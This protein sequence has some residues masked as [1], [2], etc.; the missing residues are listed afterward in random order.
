MKKLLGYFMQIF[1][2]MIQMIWN[3]WFWA[4]ASFLMLISLKKSSLQNFKDLMFLLEV[5]SLRVLECHLK[6]LLII[7]PKNLIFEYRVLADM[8]ATILLS[9]SVP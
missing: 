8:I 2:K 5:R 3:R 6:I 9:R 4:L 1:L 7:E